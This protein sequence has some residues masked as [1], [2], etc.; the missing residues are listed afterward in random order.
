MIIHESCF[1][2]SFF[3]P[4]KELIYSKSVGGYLTDMTK[5]TTES[6][7]AMISS[8]TK[9]HVFSSAQIHDFIMLK[10]TFLKQCL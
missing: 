10:K 8:K 5:K 4:A 3:L 6:V 7:P 9:N 1:F 2:I